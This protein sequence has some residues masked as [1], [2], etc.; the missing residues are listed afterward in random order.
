MCSANMGKAG[1]RRHSSP[2]PP[3]PCVLCP[4]PHSPHWLPG[5]SGSAAVRAMAARGQ[6]DR[7]TLPGAT[8]ELEARQSELGQQMGLPTA[9]VGGDGGR[10]PSVGQPGRCHGSQRPGL[11]PSTPLGWDLA[12]Q[13]RA[14]PAAAGTEGGSPWQ[15]VP[16]R[17]GWV[18]AEV[19]GRTV[20]PGGR[21]CHGAGRL[22]G[23]MSRVLGELRVWLMPC[24]WK[25]LGWR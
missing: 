22:D 3:H 6:P 24:T 23:T 12:W 20:I 1:C 4:G 10:S 19:G 15:G 2:P 7:L 14:W 17:S 5:P 21:A 11:A 13:H 16:L 8:A 9:V 25:V 18:C